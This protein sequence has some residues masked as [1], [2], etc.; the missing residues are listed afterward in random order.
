MTGYLFAAACAVLPCACYGAGRAALPPR[1]TAAVAAGALCVPAAQLAFR[2]AP[3][4][5]GALT[6]FAA[7]YLVFA[8]LPLLA[9]RYVARQR[10]AAEQERLRERLRIA[11]DMHDS[12]GRRLSIAAVQA[13]ALEVSGLPAPQHDAVTRLGTAIR[14]SVTELHGILGVLR[15]DPQPG[16][17]MSAVGG[18]IDEF[19]AAG[20]PVSLRSRGTPRPLPPQADEA[21]YRVIEEGL[22]NAVRHAPGQPV[23]VVV[24][25][26]ARALRLTV[27]NTAQRGTYTP[28]S[29]LADLTGRL[30]HAGGSLSHG[31]ADGQFRLHAVVPARRVPGTGKRSSVSALGLAAGALLL[32]ILPAAVLLGAR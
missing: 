4:T 21:A 17:G 31:L 20:A 29:G 10:Q 13:A 16:R 30:R 14:A 1:W 15:G 19:R 22:T 11:R 26:E 28:G 18:L 12:L 5:I 2:P 25:W 27:A 24:A 9:G 6:G 3:G 7:A 32:V 8:A 23:S